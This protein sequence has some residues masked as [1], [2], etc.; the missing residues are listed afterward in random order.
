[1][2]PRMRG[3]LVDW[4]IDLHHKFNQSSETL[5]ITVKIIDRVLASEQVVRRD[6]QLLGV[7][8]AFIASKYQ[9]VLCVPLPDLTYMTARAFNN[10]DVRRMETAVFRIIEFD[11]NFPTALSFVEIYLQA[12]MCTD[13]PTELFTRLLL[14]LALTDLQLQRFK[15]STLALAAIYLA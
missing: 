9:E 7:T 12:I 8:A 15:P 5:H 13:Y 4:L 6:L 10:D 3:I 14:D 2:N 11:L 1:M